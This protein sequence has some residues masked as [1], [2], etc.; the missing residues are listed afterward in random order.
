MEIME[1]GAIGELV[2]G[3]AVIATLLYLALQIRE[4]RKAAQ[5]S[6]IQGLEDGISSL[7]SN[8][9]NSVEN[10]VLV[11]K[12]FTDYEALSE[13]EKTFL[14]IIIRRL[15]LHMDSNYW[16]FTHGVLPAELWEREQEVLRWW[17]NSPGG[18]VAWDLGGFSAPFREFVE[19][20]LKE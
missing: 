18:G 7:M 5:F 19:R 1:L 3:V 6:A 16:A 4:T 12:G 15:L 10:A 17:I 8:W 20:D 2:G 13:D 14:Q 11:N 9:S